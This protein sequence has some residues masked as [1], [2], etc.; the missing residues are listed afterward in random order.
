MAREGGQPPKPAIV[1]LSA[2]AGPI[3][4]AV[5]AGA[6]EEGVPYVLDRVADD[7]SATALA[8]AAAAR[9]PLGVGVG[10]DSRGHVCVHPDQIPA[11]LAG[12]TADAGD[13]RAARTLGHN[14]A[15]IVVGL[16]LKPLASPG[17]HAR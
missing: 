14:A 8:K 12:L 16:P 17:S 11:P 13:A 5:L 7:R 6:E 1:V 3:E 9:S 4:T 15:R 10:V 2:E